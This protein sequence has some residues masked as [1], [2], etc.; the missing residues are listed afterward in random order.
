VKHATIITG[1]GRGIRDVGE[2]GVI[3]ATYP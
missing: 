2:T 1:A 3:R